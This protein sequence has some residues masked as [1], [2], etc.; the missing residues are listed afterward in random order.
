MNIDAWSYD[1][2]VYYAIGTLRVD[3]ILVGIGIAQ[4]QGFSFRFHLL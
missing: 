2:H 4:S 1:F 3:V